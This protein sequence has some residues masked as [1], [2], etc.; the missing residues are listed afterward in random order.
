M[1]TASARNPL[2]CRFAQERQGLQPR[3]ISGWSR[4]RFGRRCQPV[5]QA[6]V[7]LWVVEQCEVV[8]A[9][10]VMSVLITPA[11]RRALPGDPGLRMVGDL[12]AAGR[13][14]SP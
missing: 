14:A 12:R 8:G 3:R 11:T 4:E 2:L 1:V 7:D 5:A 6:L 10:H 13:S 9:L